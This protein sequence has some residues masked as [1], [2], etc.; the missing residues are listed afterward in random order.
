M[1]HICTATSGNSD[2]ALEKKNM[3][4]TDMKR[5]IKQALL[6]QFYLQLGLEFE[7]AA[8]IGDVL[9]ARTSICWTSDNAII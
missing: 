3:K 1:I 8:I 2:V 5:I 6:M 9:A 7:K 4:N